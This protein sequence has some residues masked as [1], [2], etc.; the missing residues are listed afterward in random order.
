MATNT[1]RVNFRFTE[2]VLNDIDLIAEYF[3]GLDRT[4]ALKALIAEK[5]LAILAERRTG[6]A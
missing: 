6:K 4:S 1:I 5:K 3:G 2:S